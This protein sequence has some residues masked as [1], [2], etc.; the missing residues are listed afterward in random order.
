MPFDQTILIGRLGRDPEL[1]SYEG[2]PVANFSMAVD[3]VWRDKETNEKQKAVTWWD[4]AVWGPQA[5]TAGK[6]LKKGGEVMVVGRA[7]ARAYIPKDKDEP[8]AVLTLTVERLTLIGGGDGTGRPTPEPEPWARDAQV[9]G[10]E[11]DYDG[12]PAGADANSGKAPEV[13]EY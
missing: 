3:R 6:Y 12:P 7:G 11:A 9:S 8:V 5:E 1:R 13:E 2:R 4:I 10:G